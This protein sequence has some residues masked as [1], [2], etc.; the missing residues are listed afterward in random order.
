[1]SLEFKIRNVYYIELHPQDSKAKCVRCGYKRMC[2]WVNC[3][4]TYRPFCKACVDPD[5]LR[6]AHKKN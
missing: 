2:E 3:F 1:M 4:G 6:I 5:K